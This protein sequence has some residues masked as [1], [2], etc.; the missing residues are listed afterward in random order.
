M[1]IISHDQY[2]FITL[3]NHELCLALVI[4]SEQYIIMM[5]SDNDEWHTNGTP[6]AHH[7]HAILSLPIHCELRH[8]EPHTTTP[9][10]DMPCPGGYT[11]RKE[12]Q[13]L[14]TYSPTS[15]GLPSQGR[16]LTLKYLRPHLTVP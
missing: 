11:H 15:W 3:S 12:S 1:V 4:M 10:D 13:H 8:D 5:S 9:K 14:N 16:T 2:A 7:W 6:L